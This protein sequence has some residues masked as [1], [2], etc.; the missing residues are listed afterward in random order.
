M[1]VPA[2][3]ENE[4]FKSPDGRSGDCQRLFGADSSVVGRVVRLNGKPI[5]IGGT[6]LFAVL[7]VSEMYR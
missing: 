6:C 2:T 4:N 3:L 5:Q 1:A 7:P